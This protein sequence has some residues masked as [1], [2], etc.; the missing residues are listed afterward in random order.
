MGKEV[1]S[2]LILVKVKEEYVNYLRKYDNKVQINS[3]ALQKEN[4]PFVGILFK[5]KGL[6]YFVPISSNGKEKLNKMFDNYIKTGKKPIDL[7]FIEE[8]ENNKR[9][10]IS[11]LNLNNMIPVCDSAIIYYDLNKDKNYHLL[12]KEIEFCN[13][14]KEIIISNSKRIYNAVTTHS[15]SSL[16]NRCCNFK[17]L[18]E[19]CMEYQNL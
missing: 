19:K 10:M 6:K 4:K 5:V 3:R 12:R 11:V 18:E 9:K 7:F 8:M 13:K 2:R 1:T 14:N 16:E 17:I 15:W